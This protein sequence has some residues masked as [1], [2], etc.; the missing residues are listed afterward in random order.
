MPSYSMEQLAA[1]DDS[2]LRAIAEELN[3]E[4]KNSSNRQE[5]IYG[6]IDA[7][8]IQQSEQR[9][10]SPRRRQRIVKHDGEAVYT[11]NKSGK[12]TKLEE[13]TPPKAEQPSL[14][15]E[16]TPTT[17][18]RKRGRPSKVSLEAEAVAQSPSETTVTG[19]SSQKEDILDESSQ[20]SDGVEE[21]S[22]KTQTTPEIELPDFIS[23]QMNNSS[24]MTEED[25]RIKADQLDVD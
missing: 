15:D 11:A 20:I 23:A 16:A 4:N 12:A 7:Q 3:S 24:I 2:Q 14:F 13:K 1:M 9:S 22:T 8:A 25:E 6:I 17:P 19:S 18:K 5:I 10:D 21:K